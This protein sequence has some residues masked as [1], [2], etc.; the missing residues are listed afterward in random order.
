MS[1]HAYGAKGAAFGEA[2]HDLQDGVTVDAEV[3]VEVGDGAGLAEMFDAKA[4]GAVAV[5]GAEP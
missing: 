4:R 5:D 2:R 1:A 3:A